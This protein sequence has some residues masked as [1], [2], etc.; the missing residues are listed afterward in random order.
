MYM[1]VLSRCNKL[2]Y[3][4]LWFPIVSGYTDLAMSTVIQRLSIA[5]TGTVQ[6]LHFYLSQLAGDVTQSN[7]AG[8]VVLHVFSS[9]SVTLH[10]NMVL[11]EV[12]KTSDVT[13]ICNLLKV[14]V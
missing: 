9:I 5:Y 2:K 4:H 10:S 12:R 8:S 14:V 7:A 11:V 1:L 6:L 3:D 13:G